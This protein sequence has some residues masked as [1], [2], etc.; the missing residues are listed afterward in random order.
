MRAAVLAVGTELLLG[1]VVNSNAAWLGGRLAASGCQVVTSEAL[2][3]DLERLVPAIRA[4]LADAD[5]V[6]LCGGLGPTLDDLTRE[7]LA[8]ALDAPLVRDAAVEDHLRQ[9]LEPRFPDLPAEVFRQ[10]DVP[11]GAEALPNPAGTAPGLWLERDGRVVVALPGPPHELQAVSSAVWPRLAHRSGTAVVTRQVLVAG[12]PESLVAQ[13]VEAAVTVPDGVRLSY[14]AGAGVVRVRFT[15]QDPA[16]L[17]PLVAAADEVLGAAVLG[18]DDDTLPRVVHRLLLERG[19]TVGVA[20]S[21]T[22][23]QLS[24]ALT[25]QSGASAT[26]RGGLVVYATELKEQLAAVPDHVL[27][28]HGPVAAETATALAAGARDRLGADWGL[29]VTGVAGPTE[30]D[31]VPVGTVFVAVAGPEGGEVRTLELPGSRDRVRLLTVTYA[32][33]LLRRHLLGKITVA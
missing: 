30:Q 10:A 7:A 16:L 25:E 5:V 27:A 19:Q 31:G 12:V 11:T 23:G 1:D 24:A 14:L 22:G 9:L 13:R 2:P 18:H 33:D 15:G 21:L 3:D 6:V 26:F 32:L 4:A 8:A 29:G 20:E 28:A 17:D